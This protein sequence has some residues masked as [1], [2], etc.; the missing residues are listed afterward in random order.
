MPST[1]HTTDAILDAARRLVLQRGT[2]NASVAA[3]S[4]ESGAPVGSLYHQFGS[5]DDL[6]AALWARAVRRSQA[7]FIAAAA[8]RDPMRAAVGAALSIH[9][10]VRVHPEDAR[11]LVA[12]RREDLLHDATSRPLRR[13]LDGLNRPLAAAVTELAR[14]LY[15]RATT[16]TIE[17][18]TVA[19]VDIPLGVVRRHLVAGTKPPARLRRHLETAVRAVLVRRS[20]GRGRL[21]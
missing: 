9:D 21:D 15:G 20:R 4:K 11:L 5:R 12:F 7:A 18:T 8:H 16:A 3:I 17:Q 14:R 10:F 6:V 19:V 1:I 13:L 2:Q